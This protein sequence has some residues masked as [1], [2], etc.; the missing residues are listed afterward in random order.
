[1]SLASI[2]DSFLEMI[3]YGAFEIVVLNAFISELTAWMMIVNR[4]ISTN[5]SNAEY[6]KVAIL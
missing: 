5:K 2:Y 3:D 1:M 4:K 6:M